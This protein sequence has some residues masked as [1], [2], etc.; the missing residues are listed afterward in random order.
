MTV[1]QTPQPHFPNSCVPG[2]TATGPNDIL[3]LQYEQRTPLRRTC[4]PPKC[5]ASL[6]GSFSLVYSLVS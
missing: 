4:Y 6:N 5:N 3:K 1:N 2:L